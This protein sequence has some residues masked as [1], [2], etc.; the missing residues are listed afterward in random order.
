MK[1]QANQKKTRW[2]N[3]KLL[4]IF[5]LILIACATVPKK[6]YEEKISEWKSY[7]DV[8]KWMSWN[9]SYDMARLKEV[10]GKDPNIV[11]P[12]SPQKTFE[13]KS[14]VCFDAAVFAIKTL[15]RIDPSYEAEIVFMERDD[16]NHYVCS[17]KKGGELYIMDF[18]TSIK[19][20]A[21]V[22]GPYNSLKEYKRFFEISYPRQTTIKSI[23]FGWPEWWKVGEETEN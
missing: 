15:N 19:S 16:G 17:F 6:T 7:K 23:S 22:H 2:L 12:R 3:F 13:L 4:T 8:A 21:G 20:V 10:K 9:F 1:F 18:G 11:R 14:G 5:F